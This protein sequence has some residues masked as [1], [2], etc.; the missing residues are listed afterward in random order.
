MSR[1]VQSGGVVIRR[2]N[3]RESSMIVDILTEAHGLVSF[4]VSGVRQKQPRMSP[5][6][7]APGYSIDLVFYENAHGKL[8]RIKEASVR[9]RYDQIPFNIVRRN[10][11][12]CICVLIKK[13][14]HW[15]NTNP[16]FLVFVTR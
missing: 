12:L 6:L 4:I 10:T 14:V 7:F 1:L 9:V 8:W 5:V 11:A 13:M 15:H 16:A 2:M 3:Y